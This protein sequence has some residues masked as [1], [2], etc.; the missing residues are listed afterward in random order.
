MRLSALTHR[1]GNRSLIRRSFQVLESRRLLAAQVTL[2]LPLAG[3]LPSAE[4]LPS[5][6][7]ESDPRLI[8]MFLGPLMPGRPIPPIQAITALD[9]A[10]V[11]VGDEFPVADDDDNSDQ[12]P[13]QTSPF[14]LD[15]TFL[16]NSRPDS[17]FTIYL[18]FDG[19]TTVG[20]SW[21]S[22]YGMAEIEHPNYWG[23]SGPI[24]SNSQ[25]E[26]IQKI[27][28]VVAEDF[29]PFD[30]NVTTAEPRDL[31]DLRYGGSQDTR[32]GTRAVMTKDTFADCGCGGH[33]YLGAFDDPQDE[34]ALIYNGGLGAGSETVSHEVGHQLG[35]HHD[36][37][38]SKTYYSGHGSGATGWGPIMGSPFSK[39]I[40]QWN[41]G[42]YFNATNS[43]DDDLAIITRSVNFP[44]V[45]DDHADDRLSATALKESDTIDVSALGIIENNDDVDW[46][47]FS[48]AAGSVSLYVDALDYKPNLDV[49][50]G[51]Y[52]STGAFVAESNPADDPSAA[53][54]NITLDA[55]DY[56]LKID[57]VARDVVYDSALDAVVEP[58]PTPYSLASPQGYS[59]YGSLGQYLVHGTVVDQGLPTVW[60]TADSDSVIEGD[61]ASFTL[62]SSD[63][64]DVDVT[65]AIRPTRQPAPGSPAPDSTEPDDFAAPLT[66][67][68][69]ILG[70]TATV[71]IP[72]VVDSR[73]ENRERFEVEIIDAGGH[74]IANRTAAMEIDES[75]TAYLIVAASASTPEGDLADGARQTFTVSRRGRADIAQ[76]IEW[77]RIATGNSPADETDFVSPASGTL[78]FAAGETTQT[79]T[80]DITGDLAIEPDETYR[81]ELSVPSGQAFQIDPARGAAEGRILND[82][83]IVT[84]GSSAQFRLRQVDFDQGDLDHWAVDDFHISGT[85]IDDDFD[86]DLDPTNWAAVENA[87]T[88]SLFPQTDGKAL[89]FNGPATPRAVTTIPVSPA[90]GSTAEFSILFADQ[91]TDDLNATE[92]GEDVVLEYSFDGQ[93]WTE[94]QRFDE[95]EYVDW[96]DIVVQLPAES[97]F[98]PTAFPEGNGGGSNV[99]TIS[100]PRVGFIDKSITVDWTITPTGSQTV[101]EMDFVGG[102]PSGS[103][104]IPAGQSMAAVELPLLADST[105]EP[106]ETFLLTVTA[107]SGGP[108]MNATLTGVLV[109]DD[110]DE[111]ELVVQQ[112]VV[113]GDQSS[114]SQVT[115]LTVRFNHAVDPDTLADAFEIRN[116]TTGQSLSSVIAAVADPY[117][118]TDVWLSFASGGSVIDRLGSG[119]AANSLADGNYELRVVAGTVTMLGP[120]AAALTDDYWFGSDGSAVVAADAFFRFFG[121]TDGDRDVDGQDYARFGQSFLQD[122]GTSG[123]DSDLDFIG[124]GDVDGQD[125]GYFSKRFLRS[126][127]SSF[128]SS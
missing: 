8:G 30:V 39:Q 109:N 40:T 29:A 84:L 107:N 88:N 41:N 15:Q 58:D 82:E 70:G 120:G 26:L 36:G 114:R 62:T 110:F 32:W 97:T 63:G 74:Q 60:I 111:P 78:V 93:R 46:F 31:D 10:G 67:I 51:L 104:V 50:A 66:Q 6:D 86:P 21:N 37:F 35:L 106:D 65:V 43:D 53:F 56:F 23:G 103:L 34:P 45:P 92:S 122:P 71:S 99:Q 105:I 13:L 49:W 125:Y 2:P 96:T 89:F 17:N 79:L 22:G 44:Y 72:T 112:V 95:S 118:P 1:A 83:S 85:V 4:H 76:T 102:L 7:F 101:D 54:D 19:H 91:D 55:G 116:L 123:F 127:V 57:G 24:T 9:G 115:S 100:I 119:G 25:L 75:E 48:T 59:D 90:P 33:A 12:Q 77:Q 64:G 16:L 61:D 73:V 98:A 47:R 11:D 113:N 128:P 18:D 81:I 20:T 38:G 5:A 14:S 42:D 124:D 52:D 27:W 117:Q 3:T 94:I 121:D 80:I 126:L 68:V 108:I 87:E 69:S 28:Q